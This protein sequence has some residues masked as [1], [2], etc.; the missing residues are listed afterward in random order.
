[1]GVV[2]K[3]IQVSLGRVVAL[4]LIS[5]E[6]AGSRDFRARFARESRIAASIDHPHVVS[7]FAAGDYEGHPY[8]AMQ[9]IEGL[10]LSDELAVDPLEPSRAVL[11]VSQISGALDVAHAAGLVHRDVKPANILL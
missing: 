4:K 10:S 6:I 1:M 9:W 7:I 5:P 3:A 2:Y 11:V 8:I